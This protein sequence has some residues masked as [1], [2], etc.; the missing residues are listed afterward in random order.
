VLEGHRASAEA[1]VADYATGE[2]GVDLAA[3][4]DVIAASLGERDARCP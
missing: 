1:A 4:V 3:R 2:L